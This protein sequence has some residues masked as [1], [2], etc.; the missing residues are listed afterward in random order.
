MITV[1]VK[2]TNLVEP[3]NSFNQNFQAFADYDSQ[4][5]LTE[6]QS[7]LDAQIVEQL[8]TDIYQ[9]AASNW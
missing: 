5:L 6:V 3:K 1:K 7:E 4:Q 2:F 9:A 8:V